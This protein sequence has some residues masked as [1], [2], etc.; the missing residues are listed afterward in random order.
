MAKI[1]II[2]CQIL[3][4]ELAHVLSADMEVSDVFVV[5]NEFSENL[6]AELKGHGKKGVHR[7]A[8]PREFSE[9][10]IDGHNVL[11][12]VMELGLH[13]NIKN[14]Q[15]HVVSAVKEITRTWTAFFSDT[16]CVEIP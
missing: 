5:D 11:I 1:G 15:R 14:L 3:E 6:I 13:S 12:R 7:L 10:P 8:D 16:A 9:T 4:L 2:T